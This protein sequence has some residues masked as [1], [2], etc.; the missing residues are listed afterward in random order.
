MT[1]IPCLPSPHWGVP[2]TKPSKPVT[3]RAEDFFKKHI[4]P[5]SPSQLQKA[6]PIVSA[7]RLA[8]C[9]LFLVTLFNV[10]PSGENRFSP[11]SYLTSCSRMQSRK[12]GQYH[13]T[14][15]GRGLLSTVWIVM[16][17]EIDE[18]LNVITSFTFGRTNHCVF[19]FLLFHLL[20]HSGNEE[21]FFSFQ[22]ILPSSAAILCKDTQFFFTAVSMIPILYR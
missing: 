6:Q 8:H 4:F 3:L 2:D 9:S 20:F 14:S 17:Y 1:M 11:R 10:K 18:L 16:L 15:L 13:Q 22:L 12:N 5:P 19:V 7:Q 21:A